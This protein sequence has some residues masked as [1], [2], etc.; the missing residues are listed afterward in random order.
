METNT[1]IQ[2]QEIIYI[3]KELLRIKK[4]LDDNSIAYPIS[5]GLFVILDKE[6]ADDIVANKIKCYAQAT[7][8]GIY[9]VSYPN[10]QRMYLQ[11]YITGNNHV[12]FKNKFTLDCRK[13]NLVGKKRLDVMRNR[14]GKSNTS[15]KYK[16]VH[17]KSDGRICCEIKDDPNKPRRLWL[18]GHWLTQEDA[19]LMYDAA[20]EQLYGETGFMNFP[21]NK[22]DERFRK[23]VPKYLEKR[24]ERERKKKEKEALKKNNK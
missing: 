14:T 20:V 8:S 16:G 22:I 7:H 13:E 11:Q 23:L 21:N 10:K 3:R 19:A 5:R 2:P 18:G 9:A 12:T 24:E 4:N 6:V 15:T 17:I 1:Q